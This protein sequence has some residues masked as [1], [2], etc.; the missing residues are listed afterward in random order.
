[1]SHLVLRLKNDT[2]LM[3]RL[4]F[5]LMNENSSYSI[6]E[7]REEPDPIDNNYLIIIFTAYERGPYC[8]IHRILTEF[9]KNNEVEYLDKSSADHLM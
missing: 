2:A 3:S 4:L 1:M 5:S 6:K 8:P 9:I 7:Y